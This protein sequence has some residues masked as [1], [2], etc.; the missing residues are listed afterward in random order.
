MVGFAEAEEVAHALEDWL[1][2]HPPARVDPSG[3]RWSRCSPA[4]GCW[5]MPACRRDGSAA[6]GVAEFVD[7]LRAEMV[8]REAAIPRRRPS[9]APVGA[10]LG[11]DLQRSP[12]RSFARPPWRAAPAQDSI[13]A[14]RGAGGAG[15]W[16]GVGPRSL[17]GALGEIIHAAPRVLPGRRRRGSDFQVAAR[18][19]RPGAPES[20]A[21]TACTWTAETRRAG[22]GP[23][24]ARAARGAVGREA[25]GA[26]RPSSNVVRV[27]LPRLDELMRLVGELVISRVAP[28][29]ALAQR[30][31]E[32]RRHAR[33]D[34]LEEIND[35]DG[36]AAARRCA[37]V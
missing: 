11:P 17:V 31:L 23:P 6:G 27:D 32:R 36:A 30:L 7:G 35:G 26:T 5:R 37:K 34:A 22:A 28:R 2:A 13:R 15:H 3:S 16:R 19:R 18:P 33:S 20:G 24:T 14:V 9:S 10:P 12:R 8:R 1:R 29:R 4:R 25:A 21:L